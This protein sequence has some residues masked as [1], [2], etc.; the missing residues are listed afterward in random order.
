MHAL[1]GFATTA[2]IGLVALFNPAPLL[3]HPG[4]HA[5]LSF[6]AALAHAGQASAPLLAGT[7]LAWLAWRGIRRTLGRHSTR[8][9]RS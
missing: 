9:H 3:A 7:A 5:A 1:I 6:A 8:P 4:D 2:A